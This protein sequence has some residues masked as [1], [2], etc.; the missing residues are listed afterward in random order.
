MDNNATA[1]HSTCTMYTLP[2]VIVLG[3]VS[4]IEIGGRMLTEKAL[5]N[6]RQSSRT[7]IADGRGI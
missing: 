5:V 6:E 1:E 3:I 2:L 7:L 4:N